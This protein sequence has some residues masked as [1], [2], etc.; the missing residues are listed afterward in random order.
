MLFTGCFIIY[1]YT[2]WSFVLKNAVKL[3]S[4]LISL[5]LIISACCSS[6]LP[7]L[8]FFLLPSGFFHEVIPVFSLSFLMILY[9][10]EALV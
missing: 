4:L 1:I 8:L 7:S 5:Q 6:I 2:A 3:L 9:L 10:L